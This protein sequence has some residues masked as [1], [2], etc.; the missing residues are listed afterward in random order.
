MR[1]L[2]HW[3]NIGVHSG[4]KEYDIRRI[5]VLNIA[6]IAILFFTAVLF[7]PEA[8]D[9]KQTS[10]LFFFVNS[11]SLPISAFS[12]Y[13]TH[14]RIYLPAKLL[15]LV[16]N[17]L[18]VLCL[19]LFFNDTGMELLAVIG[20]IGTV[21]LFEKRSITY[22]LI[23]F[24]SVVYLLMNN[25]PALLLQPDQYLLLSHQLA[26][27]LLVWLVLWAVSRQFR[28]FHKKLTGQRKMLEAKNEQLHHANQIKAKLFSIVS[29]D[30]KSPL[31]AFELYLKEFEKGN[32]T[33][34]E[35]RQVFPDMLK[36]LE[37]IN[38][39]IRNLLDW[40]RS[41][42][43]TQHVHWEMLD[44]AALVRENFRLLGAIATR[45]GVK[46]E[47]NCETGLKLRADREMVNTI[48][49]NLVINAIKFSY[50]GQ[51]VTLSAA[52]E[53]DHAFISISDRGRGMTPEQIQA[54]LNNE[55]ISTYGTNQEAG[56]GL[57]LL[58]IRQLVEQ[59]GGLLHICSKAGVGTTMRV[60]L[61]LYKEEK[62]SE[63][64][65]ESHVA[66]N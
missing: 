35:V 59:Q 44:M 9:G 54:I 1:R 49:R 30:L 42:L 14:R 11:L 24:C 66:L 57:G 27:L 47:S 5:R 23:I 28:S 38:L 63:V 13:L 55:G 61:P 7:L 51:T 32:L 58:L 3:V 12:L 16:G 22:G 39:L 18:Q 26:T 31:G 34:Q 37:S 56:S 25:D 19:K 2:T 40:A 10:P 41:Q 17:V 8:L 4:L 50:T 43:H 33:D 53:G 36:D 65:I 46:L 6:N 62:D 45:K 48:I 64:P 29:H 60:Q 15:S 52:A 20:I 21:F